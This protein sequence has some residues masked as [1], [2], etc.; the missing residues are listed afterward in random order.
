MGVMRW[1]AKVFFDRK[2]AKD[3]KIAKEKMQRLLFLASFA[4][5]APWR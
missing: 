1:D 5:L 3:A 2:G 4:F